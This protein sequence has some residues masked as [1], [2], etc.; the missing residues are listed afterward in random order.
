[1]K[2]YT[3]AALLIGALACTDSNTPGPTAAPPPPQP[4]PGVSFGIQP[5][6]DTVAIG[7]TAFFVAE[8]AD[9]TVDQWTVGDSMI[10]SLLPGAVGPSHPRG[11]AILLAG[12]VGTVTIKARR[13]SDSGQATLVVVPQPTL[14]PQTF[15]DWEAIDLGLMDA[16]SGTASDINDSGIIVGQF[17][18]RCYNGTGRGFVFKDGVMRK[19]AGAGLPLAI[20][21][22][23]RIAGVSDQSPRGLVVW[24]NPDATSRPLGGSYGGP[25]FRAMNARGDIIVNIEYVGVTPKA[26]LWRNDALVDLGFLID[27]TDNYP[28]TSA[29]A[30]NDRGQIVGASQV[31]QIH[32]GNDYMEPSQV[33]HAFAWEDGIM[34]DLGI[35][36]PLPCRYVATPQDCSWSYAADINAHG[37][38]VGTASDA[39]GNG[40]AVVWENGKISD[41]G[42]YPDRWTYA[43]MINDR[44]QILGTVAGKSSSE[45]SAFF[46]ENGQARTITTT[47][48]TRIL[49]LGLNGEVIGSRTVAT[50]RGY[51]EYGFVWQ[52]GQMS[53]LGPGSL[54]AINARSEIV[55]YRQIRGY[56]RPTLWRKKRG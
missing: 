34:R 54:S 37:V 39:D 7:D 47:H 18:S 43:W 24:D 53:E 44:G 9:S 32:Y 12:S 28:G 55:G 19:L 50:G 15:G 10:A 45:D 11:R 8:R 23:G 30:L 42:V 41:L 27:S 46:W 3:A 16:C 22:S 29:E 49:A 35:L 6:V 4:P 21:A 25:G 56:N 40:H 20:N 36:A 48:Y 1:M 2:R 31:T 38:I 33:W 13:Q 52:A 51:V 14:P 5:A 26:V 17:S